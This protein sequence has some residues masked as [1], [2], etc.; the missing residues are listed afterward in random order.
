MTG[1]TSTFSVND[2]TVSETGHNNVT[3]SETG[4]TTVDLNLTSLVHLCQLI[5]KNG[6]SKTVLIQL[7]E[8]FKYWKT[9]NKKHTI[10]YYR[11]RLNSQLTTGSISRRWST[12]QLRPLKDCSYDHADADDFLISGGVFQCSERK[13]FQALYPPLPAPSWFFV[14]G[15]CV[16]FVVGVY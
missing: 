4:H 5:L 14:W 13:L 3:V 15:V 1:V 2:V 10:M 12:T 16:C 8:S 11:S 6:F 7:I 9:T